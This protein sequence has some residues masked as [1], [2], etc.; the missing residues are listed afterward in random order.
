M[1]QMNKM[2]KKIY[3]ASDHGGFAL[4]NTLVPFLRMKGFSVEDCGPLTLNPTDD[5]PD[6]TIPLAK[7]VAGNPNTVGILLCRNGQGV[8]IVANKI[9]GIRAVTGFSPMMVKSTRHDDNANVL[10]LPAD[11]VTPKKAKTMASMWLTTPFSKK[12]RHLRRLAKI[13]MVERR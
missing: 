13:K 10:C 4:K 8:C 11:Y 3:I 1:I 2:G 6:Y 5:Y 12:Q 9:R 7:K